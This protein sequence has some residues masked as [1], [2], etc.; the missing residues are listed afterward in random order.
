MKL[1]RA[2]AEAEDPVAAPGPSPAAIAAG[3]RKHAELAAGERRLAQLNEKRDE[4][5]ARQRSLTPQIFGHIDADDVGRQVNALARQAE[6]LE[7]K[8]SEL[9]VEMA[10]ARRA[11]AERVSEVLQPIRHEAASGLVQ[12]LARIRARIAILAECE[13]ATNAADMTLLASYGLLAALGSLENMAR[14]LAE[15]S[16]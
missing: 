12:D 14:G 1:S 3:V 2:R 6:V 11:H 10:P 7:Q 5:R 15:S 4:L 16:E 8:A 9:R 13:V